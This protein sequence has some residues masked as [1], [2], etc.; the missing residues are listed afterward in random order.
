[1]HFN[2]AVLIAF[3]PLSTGEKIAT[4]AI[5]QTTWGTVYDPAYVRL[6]YPNGDLP[7]TMGVCTDVVIRALRSVGKDLQKLIHEDA[8]KHP[9][10]YSRIEKLDR[11]IDHRRCPNQAAFFKAHGKQLSH[12]YKASSAQA[13]KPGDFVFWKLPNGRDHVGVV[14]MRRNAD[15]KPWVVH[16]LGGT[17]H[18]DVLTEWKLV[19]RFRYP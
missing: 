10:R 14:T 18:E 7:R 16:N 19:G 12:A 1:V 15:G 17:R 2:A 6:R 11:N 13:W 9:T 4:H 3:S 8:K 5:E